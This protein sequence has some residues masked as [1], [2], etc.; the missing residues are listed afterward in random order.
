MRASTLASIATLALVLRAWPLHVFCLNP[1][2]LLVP[3]M[4]GTSTP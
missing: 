3:G 4:A 1:D 2:H